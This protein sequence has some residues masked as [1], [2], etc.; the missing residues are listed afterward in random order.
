MTAAHVAATTRSSKAIAAELASAST[1]QLADSLA[2]LQEMLVSV[3]PGQGLA[4][5]RTVQL[6]GLG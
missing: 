4:K 6:I 3:C 1:R 5:G 2:R